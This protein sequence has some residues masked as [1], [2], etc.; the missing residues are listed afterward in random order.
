MN[1]HRLCHAAIALLVASMV[2]PGL[3]RA[4]GATPSRQSG[5]C[6]GCRYSLPRGD[7]PA[8]IVVLLHGDGESAAAVFDA[9]A[10]AAEARGIAVFAPSCP[11][12]EG[13][14]SQSW[15][16]WNGSPAWLT[17]Q[18]D[19]LAKHRPLDAERMWIVGWSGGASYIGYRSQELERTFAAIVIHGGGMRPAS[20]DCAVSPAS[21]SFLVGDKNPLHSLAV[22]LRDHYAACGNDLSWT[23]LKGADHAAEWRALPAHREAIL[24]WLAT[25]RR[26]GR[27]PLTR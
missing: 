25:R 2:V 20:D 13:C 22:E 26:Q 16:R 9:W 10:S 21:V 4:D 6:P 24:D 7:A 17:S 3:A 18:I 15:W 11:R 27:T 5:P 14:A 1:A 8:P 19:V 23:L 12:D